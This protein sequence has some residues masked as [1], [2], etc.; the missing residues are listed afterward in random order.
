MTQS[1]L[2]TIPDDQIESFINHLGRYSPHLAKDI[3][4]QVLDDISD[5]E[6]MKQTQ[7]CLDDIEWEN[8]FIHRYDDMMEQEYMRNQYETMPQY[9][10]DMNQ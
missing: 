6:K 2:I 3:S 9:I 1:I 10:K 4:I 5:E 8:Q 7:K